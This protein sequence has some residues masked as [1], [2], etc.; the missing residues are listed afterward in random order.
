[1]PWEL[2]TLLNGAWI[3]EPPPGAQ[4]GFYI[5]PGYIDEG[6]FEGMDSPGPLDSTWTKQTEL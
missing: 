6:Y 1:M 3:K 5:E 2:Q 4:S